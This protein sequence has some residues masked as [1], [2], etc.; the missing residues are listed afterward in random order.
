M[1]NNKRNIEY[2]ITRLN[3]RVKNH[4]EGA[5]KPE[6]TLKNPSSSVV[7]CCYI[8]PWIIPKEENAQWNSN[9][10]CCCINKYL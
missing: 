8:E 9:E 3:M 1:L 2:V 4:C 10:R 5:T 6:S 7:I